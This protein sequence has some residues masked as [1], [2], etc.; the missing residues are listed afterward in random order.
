MVDVSIFV[1]IAKAQGHKVKGGGKKVRGEAYTQPF[2]HLVA[3]A[4]EGI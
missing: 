2:H 1:F 4:S 3:Q